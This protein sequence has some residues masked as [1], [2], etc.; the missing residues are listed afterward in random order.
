M[1]YTYAMDVIRYVDCYQGHPVPKTVVRPRGPFPAELM[2][3]PEVNTSNLPA[4]PEDGSDYNVGATAQNNFKGFKW[5]RCYGCG[6]RVK[7]TETEQ[8][9]C[10]D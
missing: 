7:S 10:E 8:H 5:M 2:R 1:P 4:Y 3:V 9:V 6:G